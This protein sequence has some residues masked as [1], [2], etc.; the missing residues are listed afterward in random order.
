MSLTSFF[1]DGVRV[2]VKNNKNNNIID[3]L[4]QAPF[5]GRMALE[6]VSRRLRALTTKAWQSHPVRSADLPTPMPPC[7]SRRAVE[8]S[9][10]TDDRPLDGSIVLNRSICW[11]KSFR[12]SPA[13]LPEVQCILALVAVS[14]LGLS[15]ASPFPDHSGRPH[16]FTH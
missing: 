14:Q 16:P 10:V 15:S 13:L 3:N 11:V 9:F 2:A 5:A 6:G 12:V 8:V 4:G 1:S 7:L